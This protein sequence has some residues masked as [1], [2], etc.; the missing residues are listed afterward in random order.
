MNSAQRGPGLR[1]ERRFTTVGVD[2]F[3]TVTW[4]RRRA[5]ISGVDGGVVFEQHDVEVPATWS[6]MATNVVASKYFHG[7]VGTPE[8]ESSVRQLH[9]SRHRCVAA[10]GTRGAASL[11]PP[12]TCPPSRMS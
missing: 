9:R 12:K 4:E 6:Q 8:R 7:R 2:P 5:L 11:P 1:I 3:S 10:L